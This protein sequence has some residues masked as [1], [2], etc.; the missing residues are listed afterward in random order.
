M[1]G[2]LAAL[3]ILVTGGTF[4][5]E[6][7]ELTGALRFQATHVAQI[8]ELG[9]CRIKATV[10]C[11]MM[12]D[13]LDMDAAHRQTILRACQS[14]PESHLVITHGTDTMAETAA[15][16]GRDHGSMAGKTVVLTGAMIPFAFGTSD[17][18]FNLGGAV[19]L[20]QALP[21]G[22]YIGMNGQIFNWDNVRKNRSL[23]TFEELH[24]DQP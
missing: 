18:L 8:L 24:G 3:R 23:G 22:V 4:D 12:I 14:A 2:T 16:L 21:P 5:K 10:E 13:S 11:L 15:V 7:D 6:Y 9:R 20:A 17:G 19:V 1:G